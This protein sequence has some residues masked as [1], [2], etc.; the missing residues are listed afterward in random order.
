M[1]R[2]FVAALFLMALAMPAVAGGLATVHLYVHKTGK[3]GA[4]REV[5][6]SYYW[7]GARTANGERFNPDGLTAASHDYAVNT[8]I[9]VTNPSNGRSCA[10][11]VNDRGP[12]GIALHMGAR[13][14]FARGAARCLGM[15][16]STYVCAPEPQLLAARDLKQ[17]AVHHLKHIA[18]RIQVAAHHFKQLAA[19]QIK[20]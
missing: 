14:D 19:H 10:V 2:P 11:R 8:V 12:Y 17:V 20:R 3:C 15:I 9:N 18:H 5:L 4:Q 13:I 16:A 6:A 1:R 7:T